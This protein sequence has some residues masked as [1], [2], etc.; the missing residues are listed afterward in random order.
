LGISEDS[1]RAKKFWEAV[2][3]LNMNSSN[4][5]YPHCPTLMDSFCDLLHK[6]MRFEVGERDM[7]FMFHELVVSSKSGAK[8]KLTS[9][10]IE[11]GNPTGYSAMAKT[12]GVPAAMATEM[13]IL[14]KVLQRGV[15]A[16]LE[17]SIY[18]PLL[19]NLQSEGIKFKEC[20][21]DSL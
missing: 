9:T 6:K 3:F 21:S 11:Y 8:Q 16:P 10:L 12:V 4:E 2:N 18:L 19:S 17:K 20:S 14:G 13:I 5:L 1:P 7:A 15:V